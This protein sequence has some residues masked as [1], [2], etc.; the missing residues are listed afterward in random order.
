MKPVVIVGAGWSGAVVAH[1]L[2]VAGLP[3]EILERAPV[4]GGHS[5]VETLGGVVYEPHGPHI[6]HT[7]NRQVASFVS[8]LGI[9]R[10]FSFR[11]LTEIDVDGE[12]RL[13]SWPI[14]LDE[15]EKLPDWST[16]ETE[17]AA[18]P[19]RPSGDDF[20]S[21]VVSM[22][23]RTLFD[24]FIDGYTRKQWGR[25]PSE[26]SS[27]FAP[28]RVEL[29]R[30]GDRRL[31]RDEWEFF[32]PRGPN[33]AI[34]KLVRRSAV[35]V[36]ADVRLD[37]LEPGDAS[38]FVITAALDEF[39]ETDDLEWR[40]VETRARFYPTETYD[41]TITPAYVINRPSLDVPYT[42]TVESKHATGQLVRGTVVSEE[43]P[44]GPARHYPV[45]DIDGI[46]ERR[47]AE[48]ASEI[49]K[50]LAPTPVVFAGRLAQYVYINQD[51]A[52]ERAFSAATAVR[53]LL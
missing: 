39:V 46:N 15:I 38:V 6:F 5:R 4:V 28:K 2:A 40:G 9:V 21:Y 20:E 25:P 47:N 37:D 24:R 50:R 27:S 31:F 16:I 30:D 29:R 18:L 7:S 43:Y 11:P 14:Q 23:G 49:R 42:R 53:G 10:P 51:E 44:G 8:R 26:L 17:L 19:D 48:L 36:G 1:E 45:A 52:I 32:P 13:M 33:D 12:P 41:E 22:M 35:T 34:E 3:V